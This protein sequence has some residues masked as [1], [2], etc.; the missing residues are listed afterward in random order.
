MLNFS[1]PVSR[2][3]PGHIFLRR[4]SE[5][6]M[7][8]S[9]VLDVDPPDTI[10][11][12]V[13]GHAHCTMTMAPVNTAATNMM[14]TAPDDHDRETPPEV[15]SAVSKVPMAR[16]VRVNLSLTT[17]VVGEAVGMAVGVTVGVTVGEIVGEVI[18]MIVDV[19]LLKDVGIASID[20]DSA[21]VAVISMSAWRASSKTKESLRSKSNRSI[22]SELSSFLM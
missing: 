21:G 2:G 8:P 1:V 5:V 7:Y 3:S 22:K 13:W 15:S 12:W 19:S 14:V 18:N 17:V 6:L 10:N 11:D 4:R 9:E 16:V 20:G